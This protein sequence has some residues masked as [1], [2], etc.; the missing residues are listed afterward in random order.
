VLPAPF[1]VALADDTELQPD[2]VVG[3]DGDFTERA[4][5]GAPALAVEVLSPSTRLI[6][7]H[8]KRERLERAGAGAYWVVD[9]VGRSAEA[10]LIAWELAPDGRYRQVA[11]VVG[12]QPFETSVPFPVVVVPGALVR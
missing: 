5:V 8:V 7:T 11:D 6:D 4:L 2:I 3:R 12:A 9:P 10:R 1:A